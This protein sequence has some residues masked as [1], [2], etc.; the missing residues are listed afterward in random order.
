MDKSNSLV[1]GRFSSREVAFGHLSQR[2][3]QDAHTQSIE[4]DGESVGTVGPHQHDVYTHSAAG[5]GD[6]NKD[7]LADVAHCFVVK[8]V[9]D[10][11]TYKCTER[12]SSGTSK[13]DQSQRGDNVAYS[14]QRIIESVDCQH[15]TGGSSGPCTGA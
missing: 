10:A 9:V 3:G 13:E 15:G 14:S 4:A 5:K 7:D 2:S 12:Q 8:H 1:N 6:D 11:Q